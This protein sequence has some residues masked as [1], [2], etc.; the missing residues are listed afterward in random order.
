MPDQPWNFADVVCHESDVCRFNR[1]V[2]PDRAHCD[3]VMRTRHCRCV[4]HSVPDHRDGRIL[5]HQ[6]FDGGDLILGQELGPHLVDTDFGSHCSC[7]GRVVAGE[8]H[9][10]FDT[11]CVQTRD[12]ALG[13]WPDPVPQFENAADA[14]GI[15]DR[16]QRAARAFDLIAQ[17]SRNIPAK[18]LFL[19]KPV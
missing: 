11:L 15:T 17:I 9:D 3:A 18:A 19:G 2:R 8:H 4:V 5:R 13:I 7:R 14:V 6:L 16:H 1:G 10:L 12:S